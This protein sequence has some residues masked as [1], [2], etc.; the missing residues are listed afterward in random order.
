MIFSSVL[1][2]L[3]FN[4]K[5]IFDHYFHFQ[6]FF[7]PPGCQIILYF[8]YHCPTFNAIYLYHQIFEMNNKININAVTVTYGSHCINQFFATFM[9]H[10]TQGNSIC[11]IKYKC[12]SIFV[13]FSQLTRMSFPTLVGIVCLMLMWSQTCCHTF[14]IIIFSLHSSLSHMLCL[15]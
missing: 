5:K 8:H 2:R 10:E 13:T 1:S 11:T 4:E 3:N 15:N 12:F 6:V 14:S 7:F 9:N